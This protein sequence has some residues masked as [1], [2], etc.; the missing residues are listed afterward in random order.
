MVAGTSAFNDRYH[1]LVRRLHSLSGIIPIGVFLCVHLS[2]N[3]SIMAGP[4]AFQFAVDKIHM[5]NSLGILKVVE[6]LFIFIPIAFHAIVGVIIWL[7]GKSNLSTYQYVG[8]LRYTLQRWTGIIALFFIVAHL[9]HIHWIIPGGIEFD[10]HAAAES[11]VTAM[12]AG[13]TAPIYAIGVLCAV[14]HLA[15]G[16]WT[17]LIVWGI[18]IGPRSQTI[19]GAVCAIIGIILAVFGM[20]SL[21]T[22]K[23]MDAAGAAP[24]AGGNSHT[25]IVTH[26]DDAIA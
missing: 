7:S 24:G 13:W 3:A 9:W 11:A 18:T 5:L 14:F 22:L 23:T 1:F 17:F 6:V 15:N 10:A 16:I 12:R 21:V 2:I 26:A 19:S 25:A 20:G 4:R 8:N